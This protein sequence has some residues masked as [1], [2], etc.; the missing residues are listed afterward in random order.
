MKKRPTGQYVPCDLSGTLVVQEGT[1][2]WGETAKSLAGK[3]NWSVG[4]QWA[5]NTNKKDLKQYYQPDPKALF[6]YVATNL[7]FSHPIDE[8]STFAHKCLPYFSLLNFIL[9]TRLII[10]CLWY[11]LSPWI[12]HPFP[13]LSNN[14]LNLFQI[15]LLI[16]LNPNTVS[17]LLLS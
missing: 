2:G 9:L 12:C 4:C 11:V 7:H 17:L 15:S 14:M 1:P 13:C 16:D 8:K 3:V 6:K 10:L 5:C